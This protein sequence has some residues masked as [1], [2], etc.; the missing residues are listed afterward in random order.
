MPVI[1]S[2]RERFSA[3][4]TL[5][6]PAFSDEHNREVYGKCSNPSGHGHNYILEVQLSGDIDPTTG[7]VFDL[8]ELGSLMHKLILDDVDHRN[9]NTDVD[10]LRGVIPTTENLACAFFDRLDSNLP[11]GLLFSVRLGETAKNWAERRRD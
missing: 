9:L 2:R 6:N 3:G 8:G 11:S 1:V 10:W 4:H 5:F 7:F